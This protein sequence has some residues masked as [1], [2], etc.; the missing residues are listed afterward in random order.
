MIYVI[1]TKAGTYP[2]LD[3][4]FYGCTPIVLSSL[5]VL[6]AAIAASLPVFWPIIQHNLGNIFVTYEV[7]IVT[8]ERKG[9]DGCREAESRR[10]D[11][12]PHLWIPQD[13]P[14]AYLSTEITKGGTEEDKES[15]VK[16]GFGLSRS[17]STSKMKSYG[18]TGH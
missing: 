8:E 10:S 15:L 4:T 18:Q 3:P 5:E 2:T 6:L 17:T 11:A 14:M 7:T 16:P 13:I 12:P 9:R 1:Q